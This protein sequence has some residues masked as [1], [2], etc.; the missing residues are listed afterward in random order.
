MKTLQE[1]L[2]EI[3]DDVIN[4]NGLFNEV[5]AKLKEENI[6]ESDYEKVIEEILNK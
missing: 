2:F 3:M 1:R 4:N 5:R 6:S